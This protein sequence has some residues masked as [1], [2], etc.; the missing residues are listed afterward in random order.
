LHPHQ[1]RHAAKNM[2]TWRFFLLRRSCARGNTSGGAQTM[3]TMH[4]AMPLISRTYCPRSDIHGSCSCMASCRACTAMNVPG[5][6]SRKVMT[7]VLIALCQP[8][9]TG[10]LL[11]ESGPT[12][13]VPSWSQTQITPLCGMDA[14]AH[15][16]GSLDG[17]T[18]LLP[19]Q[20]GPY[21]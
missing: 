7:G 19:W 13:R 1:R 10:A 5:F 11:Q 15:S 3:F 16:S 21:R 17:S 20:S 14:H 12:T 4:I 18:L 6:V 2:R 8:V 9:A